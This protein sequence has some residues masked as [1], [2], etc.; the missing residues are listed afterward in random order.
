MWCVEREIYDKMVGCHSL[1]DIKSQWPLEI[2][3]E[4]TVGQ[5]KLTGGEGKVERGQG[6]SNTQPQVADTQG[7]EV[8]QAT[9]AWYQVALLSGG[10]G[11]G[12]CVGLCCAEPTDTV[13]L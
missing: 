2:H 3:R 1:K 5:G 8:P 13:G 10:H 4:R 6:S 7:G 11:G 9:Q 12:V